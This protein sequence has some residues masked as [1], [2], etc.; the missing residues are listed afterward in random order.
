MV[1]IAHSQLSF[2]Q[3]VARREL[4][5]KQE[6]KT[7][8]FFVLRVSAHAAGSRSLVFDPSITH[9]RLG[10]STH[11]QQNGAPSHPQD[12]DAPLRLAAQRKII[13]YRQHYADNQSISFLPAI[14]TTS[15]RMHGE[16]LSFCGFFFY[17]TTARSR[18][19]SLPLD[20]HRN[21]TH[22]TTR[23]GSNARPSTWA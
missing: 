15:S 14:M 2:L 7:L 13:S 12:L 17:R 6:Q 23:S 11:V 4:D 21:K 8:F 20:C 18:R 5:H 16:S 3:V 19:T 9:D 22:R 10:S 1:L